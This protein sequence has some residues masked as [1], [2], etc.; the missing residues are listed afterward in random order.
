MYRGHSDIVQPFWDDDGKQ[1]LIF[2]CREKDPEATPRVV[3]F[4]SQ[5][6]RVWGDVDAGHMHTGGVAKLAPDGLTLAWVST[7]DD[8]PREFIYEARTGRPVTSSGI[9]RGAYPVD[10]NGDGLM[11]LAYGPRQGEGRVADRHG[12]R[13]A[14]FEGRIVTAGKLT[15]HPGEQIMTYTSDGA[16]RIW[17]CSSAQDM[18]RA[19]ARWANPLYAANRRVLAVGYNTKILGAFQ[20]PSYSDAAE[21][22]G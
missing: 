3:M 21:P 22:E 8:P 15:S 2:T 20:C 5:G 13:L 18:P 11:E 12:N 16:V 4:D 19:K 9:G 6:R 7:R 1:W 14:T 17:G 10:C